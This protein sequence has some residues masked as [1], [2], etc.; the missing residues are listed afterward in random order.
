MLD[1]HDDIGV[2]LHHD[3]L[4]RFRNRMP[5]EIEPVE[6]VALVVEAG[7]TAVDVFRDFI[8][9]AGHLPTTDCNRARLHV[10]DWK[11]GPVA[12]SVVAIAALSATEEPHVF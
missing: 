5:R 9:G 7:F 1:G 3:R 12:K 8:A 10:A 11:N 4:L 6:L 2:P